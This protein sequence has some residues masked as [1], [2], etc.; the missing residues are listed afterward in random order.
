MEEHGFSLDVTLRQGYE[1]G[2]DFDGDGVADLVVDE[3][4]PLGGG[5]GPNPAR[6]LAAAV[7][8]CMSASL[9]YCLR[10]ARIDVPELRTTV[11][12]RMERNERGRLRIAGLTVTLHPEL[13][14]EHLERTAR[15]REL[16]EDFCI[17]GQSVQA[18]IPLQV[19]VAPAPAALAGAPADG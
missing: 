15:C 6:L 14:P 19:E 11:H 16:F 4:P 2:V 3:P 18:G 9:L 5:A 10:R 7:G 1:L 17:V 13:G 12:A 8:S